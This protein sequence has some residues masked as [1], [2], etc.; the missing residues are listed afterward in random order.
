MVAARRDAHNVLYRVVDRCV[1]IL[2]ERGL[3][4]TEETAKYQNDFV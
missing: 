1:L 2:L 4:L 3:C